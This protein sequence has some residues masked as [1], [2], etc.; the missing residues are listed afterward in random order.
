MKDEDLFPKWMSHPH[1]VPAIL[2][3]DYEAGERPRLGY[4]A[5]PGRARSLPPVQVMDKNQE[6]YYA[7]QG[8]RVGRSGKPAFVPRPVGPAPSPPPDNGIRLI[9]GRE[10]PRWAHGPAGKKIVRSPEE[11]AAWLVQGVPEADQA[12]IAATHES[13]SRTADAPGRWDLVRQAK[14][15]GIP[16]D[17]TWKIPDLERAIAEYNHA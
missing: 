6:A 5:Q 11:E 9:D 12:A 1:E 3:D 2:S 16:A 8:Y 4:A 15:L 14:A 7:A 17:R 13:G 10:F